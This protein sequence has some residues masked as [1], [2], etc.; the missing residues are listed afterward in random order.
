MSDRKIFGHPIR[1]DTT[2]KFYP[3]RISLEDFVEIM[4]GVECYAHNMKHLHCTKYRYVEEWLECFAA[5][6]EIEEER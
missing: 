3:E 2:E 4:K 5:W 1:K 6:S